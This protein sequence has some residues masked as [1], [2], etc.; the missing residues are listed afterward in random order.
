MLKEFFISLIILASTSGLTFPQVLQQ[1]RYTV[2]TYSETNHLSYKSLRQP[3]LFPQ[4]RKIDHDT[5]PDLQSRAAL[6]MDATSGAILW[7]KNQD[8]PLPIAS[9]TKLVTSLVAQDYIT[10]WDAVYAYTAKDT[11]QGGQEFPVSIG[12]EFTKQDILKT[13]LVLSANSAASALAHSTGLS[14]EEF[15]QAM[16]AKVQQL[17]M[18]KSHFVEPTGLS[19]NNIATV[20]DL[21]LL[22]RT[23]SHYPR[24]MEPLGATEH[25]MTRRNPNTN[26]EVIVRT[27]NRLIKNHDPYVLAGKTGFTYEA[28]NCLVTVATDKSGHRIIVALLG[29]PDPTIRFEETQE[30]IQW[31]YEHHSWTPAP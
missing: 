10:N 13:A 6:I 2:P 9:I 18:T 7:E 11:A 5:G 20:Q 8:A 17:G 22:M 28:L 30:L 15:K 12:D 27:T 31:A 14:D 26:N 23:V 21:A 1:E 4:P 19:E 29:G 3:V 25:R 16:N 24:L